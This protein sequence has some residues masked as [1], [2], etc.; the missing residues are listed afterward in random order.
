M[1][2]KV[3]VHYF[4]FYHVVLQATLAVFLIA[5]I[6]H[7]IV[8][9]VPCHTTRFWVFWLILFQVP[10]AGLT[11]YISKVL[12]SDRLGNLVFW[13]SFCIFGQ[14][15]CVLLY[16]NDYHNQIVALGSSSNN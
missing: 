13:L 2:S 14:P 1:S 6:A 5:A 8:V 15:I 10:L 3:N 4:V 12:K 11:G 9:C 7:E 16:Y